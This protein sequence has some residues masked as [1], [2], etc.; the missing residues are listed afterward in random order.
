MVVSEP[1]MIFQ[2]Y[3]WMAI[4][5]LA[6]CVAACMFYFVRLLRKGPPLD[7]SSPAGSTTSGIRYA[8]TGAMSPA[9]KE[10]AFLHLPTYTAGIFFHLGTF[11]SL[12]IFFFSISGVLP[13]GWLATVIVAFIVISSFSGIAILVK[14][15]FKK[16]LRYLSNPD[17]FISN[18]LVTLFQLSTIS[19]LLPLTVIQ[20]YSHI[21]QLSNRPTVQLVY[22][23]VFTLL[24]LYLPVGKLRHTVYFFAARYHLGF[25][26]GRR[27]VWPA[28]KLKT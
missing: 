18:L 20:S 11:L 7:L 2:W 16:E 10:S 26:F 13:K 3:Q 12:L 21:V 24:M 9:R 27:G 14:R 19:I 4:F 22:Y 6:I 8:F 15:I 25:F 1:G 5:A 23:L 28:G 17:D